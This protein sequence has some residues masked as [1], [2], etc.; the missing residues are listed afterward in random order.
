MNIQDDT[1]T[2]TI[3]SRLAK[4]GKSTV[5]RVIAEALAKVGLACGVEDEPRRSKG[6]TRDLMDHC[7]AIGALAERKQSILIKVLDGKIP[8]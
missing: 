7:D 6:I 3:T 2:I 8:A 4:T 5:A 1:I